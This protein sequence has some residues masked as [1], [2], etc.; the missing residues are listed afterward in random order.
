MSKYQSPDGSVVV[1]QT[2]KDVVETPKGKFKKIS[3][4]EANNETAGSKVS[5]TIL[6]VESA[7]TI[8][9]SPSTINLPPSG[10]RIAPKK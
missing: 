9:A 7:K 3:D 5:P 10:E 1:M 2:D 4:R 6:T 8:V